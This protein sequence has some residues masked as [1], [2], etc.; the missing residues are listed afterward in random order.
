MWHAGEMSDVVP[1]GGVRP[2]GDEPW[3]ARSAPIEPAV[4][5]LPGVPAPVPDGVDPPADWR[6]LADA[7]GF[8][9]PGYQPLGGRPVHVIARRDNLGLA[10]CIAGVAG[11]LQLLIVA[12]PLIAVLAIALSLSGRRFARLDPHSVGAPVR[13]TIGLAL[14]AIGVMIGVGLF[15]NGTPSVLVG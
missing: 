10:G 11:L 2:L 4:V 7:A 12:V 13:S 6:T 3:P 5:E 8:G 15:L 14:G 9:P 1:P